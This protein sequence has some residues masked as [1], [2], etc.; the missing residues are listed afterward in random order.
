MQ[1]GL[2]SQQSKGNE[3]TGPL[4]LADIGL[5]GSFV[6][7]QFGITIPQ[8]RLYTQCAFGQEPNAEPLTYICWHD[9]ILVFG[10][11]ALRTWTRHHITYT[12]S[13]CLGYD[14]FFQQ[15]KQSS[16]CRSKVDICLCIFCIKLLLLFLLGWLHNCCWFVGMGHSIWQ[17]LLFL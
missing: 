6:Q 17:G 8:R 11:A 4:I 3:C 16:I 10:I 12:S 7:G 9:H 5:L 2:F 13:T 14:P 1:T 15:P